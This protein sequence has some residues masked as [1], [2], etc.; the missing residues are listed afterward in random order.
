M[1]KTILLENTS[2]NHKTHPIAFC[3]AKIQL[4]FQKS[5]HLNTLSL[6]IV[7]N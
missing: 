2:S 5:Q 4:N 1:V 6:A 3:L 7:Q